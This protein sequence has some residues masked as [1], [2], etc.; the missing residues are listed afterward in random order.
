MESSDY[1][2]TLT[3][4]NNVVDNG[5]LSTVD[6]SSMTA[7]SFS[8]GFPMRLDKGVFVL[9][10]THLTRVMSSPQ[11]PDIWQVDVTICIG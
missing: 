2:G 10:S 5:S 3:E 9:A 6:W 1:A 8:S 11:H 7:W 4:E